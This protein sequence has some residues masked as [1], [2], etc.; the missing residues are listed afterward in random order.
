MHPP[1]HSPT[2]DLQLLHQLPHRDILL[3]LD[4]PARGLLAKRHQQ[5]E[6]ITRVVLRG[7]GMRWRGV[8]GRGWCHDGAGAAGEGQRKRGRGT[9]IESGLLV[10]HFFGYDGRVDGGGGKGLLRVFGM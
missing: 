6:R 4:Q 7:A 8:G 9:R 10:G 1:R 2:P 3:R 5:L